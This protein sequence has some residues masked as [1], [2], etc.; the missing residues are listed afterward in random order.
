MLLQAA[1]KRF[2]SAHPVLCP[3][4]L[5]KTCHGGVTAYSVTRFSPIRWSWVEFCR[6]D[7]PGC[8]SA[9][10]VPSTEIQWDF[11][12]RLLQKIKLMTL[13]RSSGWSSRMNSAFMIYEAINE[14]RQLPAAL[15]VKVGHQTWVRYNN[16]IIIIPKSIFVWL[17]ALCIFP[18]VFLISWVY[19]WVL[20]VAL[21]FHKPAE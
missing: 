19:G 17:H 10:L 12:V 18:N 2:A 6:D 21:S 3:R 8:Y 5:N 7:D 15:L 20:V 14:L 13:S 1:E 11:Y 16:K 4:L 9:A